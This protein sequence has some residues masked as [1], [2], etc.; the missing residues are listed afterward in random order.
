[1]AK[2]AYQYDTQD[3]IPE[4]FRSLYTERDGKFELTEV[5]GIRTQG[6]FDRF[7]GALRKRLSDATAKLDSLTGAQHLTKDDIRSVVADAVK[8]LVP[9]SNKDG[10]GGDD[11]QAIH[12]LTRRMSALETENKTLKST[13]EQ[14]VGKTNATALETQIM[15]G[16]LAAGVETSVADMVVRLTKDDFELD[17]NGNAVVKVTPSVK[18]VMPNAKP[19]EY[20]K[21]IATDAAFKRFWPASTGAG[22]GGSNGQGGGAADTSAGNPFSKAGWNKTLQAQLVKSNPTEATRLASVCGV[23]VTSTAPNK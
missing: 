4:A 11:S 8:A 10:K 22:A 15:R 6:D 3:K 5:D 18:G 19:E 7:E 16:A 12:D 13:N 23:T 1:M 14:L 2:L 21:A 17:A 9:G 20:Y